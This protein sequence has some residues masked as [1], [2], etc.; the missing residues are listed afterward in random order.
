MP[1]DVRERRPERN[2]GVS[3]CVMILAV[4]IPAI[5]GSFMIACSPWS[6]WS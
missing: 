4:R 2:Y 3:P 1:T 5:G 6:I